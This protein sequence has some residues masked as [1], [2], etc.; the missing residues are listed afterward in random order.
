MTRHPPALKTPLK[1]LIR[2]SYHKLLPCVFFNY[3]PANGVHGCFRCRAVGPC[4]SA[5][6]KI[7]APIRIHC[8]ARMV[9]RLRQLL[10]RPPSKV[11]TPASLSALCA[12]LARWYCGFWVIYRSVI[13]YGAVSGKDEVTHNPKA[14][15]GLEILL[16]KRSKS[17]LE[18][19]S[20][21]VQSPSPS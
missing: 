17:D 18:L 6:K 3:T 15:N 19:K 7:A 4:V 21:T 10:A 1:R 2:F 20:I 8:R 16:L 9:N 13:P 14:D 5:S 12:I 11:E